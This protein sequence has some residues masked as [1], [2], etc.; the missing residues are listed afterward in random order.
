MNKKYWLRGGIISVVAY[1]IV[2]AGLSL[3]AGGFDLGWSIF[4]FLL[5]SVRPITSIFYNTS[6]GINSMTEY[7]VVLA[8]ILIIF[9]IIGSLLGTFYKKIVKRLN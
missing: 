6:D 7:F 2:T 4:A 8:I 3:Q 5:I 9:F 1:L